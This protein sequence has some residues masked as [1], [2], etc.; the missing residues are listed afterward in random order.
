MLIRR[1]EKMLAE[2]VDCGWAGFK[3]NLA[4]SKTAIESTLPPHNDGAGHRVSEKIES[5]FLAQSQFL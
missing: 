4:L 2:N 3:K 5:S 1:S